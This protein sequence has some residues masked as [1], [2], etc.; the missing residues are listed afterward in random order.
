MFA[1]DSEQ[2]CLEVGIILDVLQSV[3]MSCIITIRSPAHRVLIVLVEL[4]LVLLIKCLYPNRKPNSI[5]YN[6]RPF[7]PA[8][9]I[10]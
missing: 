5:P 6:N 2:P 4:V 9:I 10:S 3:I 1:F 8:S 7:Q